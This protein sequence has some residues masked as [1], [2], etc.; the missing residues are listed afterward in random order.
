MQRVR[1]FTCATAEVLI[2]DD[3]TGSD[4]GVVHLVAV[5][6][7]VCCLTAAAA[8][9]DRVQFLSNLTAAGGRRMLPENVHTQ[10]DSLTHLEMI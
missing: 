4:A 6:V 3:Q 8:A 9:G 5:R 1:V 2:V 10:T 7:R